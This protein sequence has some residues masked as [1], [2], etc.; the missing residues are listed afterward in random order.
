MF[1]RGFRR[2]ESATAQWWST[3]LRNPAVL[4]PAGAALTAAMKAKIA[5]D[6]GLESWWRS[7]GLPTKVDQERTLHAIHELES[8]LLDL[9]ERLDEDNA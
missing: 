8:R 4:Q 1:K 3:V 6:R 9:E 7:W 5:A 2:W